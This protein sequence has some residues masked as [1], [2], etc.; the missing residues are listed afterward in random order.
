MWVFIARRLAI[1]VVMLIAVS[2]LI[3]VVLRLLP[4]DPVVTR[5]G[6]T[7]GIS[8]QTISELRRDAGLDDPILTQ[9]G[10]WLGGVVQG[11]FG[12]SYFNQFSVTT[13]IGQRL[14]ATLELTF[15]AILLTIVL[16]VPA[17]MISV[18]RPGGFVDKAMTGLATA[19][20]AAPQF[21]V[22]VLLIV[23]FGVKLKWLPTRGFT[24]ITEDLG[25]NL[26]QMIL[27]S[28]T[29]AIAAAPL[30][31]RF[32]RTSLLEALDSS[33]IRTATGKG[34][35]RRSVLWTHA[36]PN[37]VIPALTMLGMIVGYT[38]GGVVIIEYV[39]G[40]PGL[41]SMAVDA[42][43]KRDYAILQ[44]VVLL[45]SAM[46]ILTT[47][48]VDIAVSLVDPRLRRGANV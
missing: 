35:D 27:P 23:I 44:S 7:P 31:M 40:L 1:S 39:F 16:A 10:R 46:F 37:A 4:G 30:L 48:L 22:G 25:L 3:F 41:G 43:A 45:I 18:R 19:G 33:Y 38:L 32:L 20:M 12:N 24:P 15:F 26:K 9:Y 42:V 13:L 47:L 14:P 11:D 17:A 21:L 8:E 29:L 2:A 34:V 36:L 28:L 5:L 6:A